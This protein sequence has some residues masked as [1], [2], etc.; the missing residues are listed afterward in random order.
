M[1]RLAGE[2][3]S[4]LHVKQL[5]SPQESQNASGGGHTTFHPTNSRASRW[6]TPTKTKAVRPERSIEFPEAESAPVLCFASSEPRPTPSRS[7][8][9]GSMSPEISSADEKT[10]MSDD[11]RF[12][13][14]RNKSKS[15]TRFRRPLRPS[16]KIS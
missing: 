12:A 14:D 10:K 2:T 13:D 5:L 9:R 7:T 15:D 16:L 8:T 6:I 11:G 1:T 4:P 3:R